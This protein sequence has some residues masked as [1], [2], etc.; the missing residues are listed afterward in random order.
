VIIGD[1]KVNS[2]DIQ[3]VTNEDGNYQVE[4]ISPPN[5]AGP[6]NIII[7]NPD[8][9]TAILEYVLN[10][11]DDPLLIE[12]YQDFKPKNNN[13]TPPQSNK[14]HLNDTQ[15]NNGLSQ[16]TPVKF[17]R[18]GKKF[19]KSNDDKLK[20]NINEDQLKIT[21][22][23]THTQK[24]NPIVDNP[25]VNMKIEDKGQRKSVVLINSRIE[26]KSKV[27]DEE[28]NQ[29]K[30]MALSKKPAQNPFDDDSG[31]QISKNP[32]DDDGL[33][34]TKKQIEEKTTLNDT[35]KN[36][37][38]DNRK[39]NMKNDDNDKNQRKSISLSKKP[40]KNPFDDDSGEQKSKKSI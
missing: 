12:A 19:K 23:D 27:K 4:V 20:T 38:E 11:T 30:S 22:E 35:K 13:V 10:Y 34:K 8:K 1:K 18:K 3:F 29:R 21:F 9:Q 37:T 40:A 7:I 15:S 2:T 36:R 14:T 16:S 25:K 26:D 28:K 32:F 31:E 24:R 33:D 39:V 6:K 5:N 17:E